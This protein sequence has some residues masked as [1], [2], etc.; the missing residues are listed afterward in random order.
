[1]LLPGYDVDKAAQAVV[2]L[3]TKSGGKINILK[4]AKLLYLAEREFMA[5]YDSPM[6]YD[7]LVSMPDGPV[8]SITLNLI[9]GDAQDAT[10]SRYVAKLDKYDVVPIKK[11]DLAEM[12]H[13]SKVDREILDVLLERFR[14]YDGFKL[15]DWTHD[16]K[17]VPEWQD[18]Q[19][20]SYEIPFNRIFSK[21][22]KEDP[23]G[24]E[25]AVNQ[26]RKIARALNKCQ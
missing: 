23:N 21:L 1:M 11:F 16:P 12:D 10:W 24:L 6:F 13:L 5:K 2:Y 4:L 14:D 20:S 8:T 18:P 19:G 3:A 9:K 22:N 7:H 15:R 25:N 17:N 26:R